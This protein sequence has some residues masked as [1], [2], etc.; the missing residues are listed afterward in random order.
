MTTQ[1]QT[2]WVVTFG[3]KIRPEEKRTITIQAETAESAVAKFMAYGGTR[4]RVLA[5]TEKGG[6]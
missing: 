5:T 6:R 3:R 4:Y 2:T 1:K